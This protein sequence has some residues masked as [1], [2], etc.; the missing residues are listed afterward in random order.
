MITMTESLFFVA[1]LVDVSFLIDIVV[2][3]S[4][5]YLKIVKDCSNE[6]R[7]LMIE[8]NVL[9]EILSRLMMLL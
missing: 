7:S 4:Y 9:C 8:V 3:K 5:Q 2:I 1:S 6:I